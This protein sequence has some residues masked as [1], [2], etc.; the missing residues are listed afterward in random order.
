ERALGTILDGRGERRGAAFLR[1]RS[2]LRLDLAHGLRE[3]GHDLERVADDAVVGDLEDRRL[4]ILVDRDD[5]LRRLHAREVLDRARD[6]DRDVEL[7]ADGLAR[8]AD[9]LGVRTPAGV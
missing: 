7:R 2:A 3:R 5:D 6:A 8:L 9:L 4:R 1:G